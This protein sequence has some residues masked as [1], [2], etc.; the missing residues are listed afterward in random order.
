[1]ITRTGPDRKPR[2]QGK[3]ANLPLAQQ[4][5]LRSWMNEGLTYKEI[6]KRAL[7]LF[8][9]SISPGSLSTYYSKHQRE[10]LSESAAPKL[11]GGGPA[12][13]VIHIQIRTELMPSS[14]A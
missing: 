1:M 8:G 11:A 12:T 7:E 2:V 13:L 4:R 6:A 3:I 14:A 5:Q 9:I 10:I